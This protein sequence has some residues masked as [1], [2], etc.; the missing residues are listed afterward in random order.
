M[1]SVIFRQLHDPR[2]ATY[3]YLLADPESREAVLIDPVFEQARRDSALIRELGVNL[4]YTL[5][6]HVHADHITG[7]W[8]LKLMTGSRIALAASANADGA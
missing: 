7:S 4:L 6:T 5:D 1:S 2:S 3:T 8:L